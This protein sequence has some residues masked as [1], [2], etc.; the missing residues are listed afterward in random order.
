MVHTRMVRHFRQ[1]LLWPLQLMPLAA[2]RSAGPHW[3]L[4]EQGEGKTIW[5]RVEDKFALDIADPS[6]FQE[7]HYKEFI[8]F[9]PHVQRFIYGE[10]RSSHRI[11]ADPPGESALKLFRRDDIATLRLTLHEGDEPIVLSVKYVDLCFFEDT[12]VVILRVEI[13]A[14]N[15]PYLVARD[16]LYRLGRSYPTEWDESGQGVHNTYRTEWL[17]ADGSVLATSDSSNRDKFL[18]FTRKHRTSGLSSHWDYLLRPLALDSS[19]ENGAIRY[20]QIEYHRMPV[21]GLLAMDS[22]RSLNREDWIRLGLIATRHPDEALPEYD[23][24]VSGFKV[25]YCYDRY[26]TDTDAGPNTR[27]LCSGRGLLIVGDASSEYFL[28]N[29]RGMLSQFRHQYS[30]MFLIAHFHR[31]SLLLFSDHLVDAIHDLNIREANSVER[32]RRRIHHSLASF[33]RFTHRY[34]FYEL[35]ERP[36]VQSLYRMCTKHLDNEAMFAEIKEELRDMSQY[37]DSDSQRRQSATVMRLTVVTTFSLIG[38]VATGF[39]GMNIIAEAD[40]PMLTRWAYFFATV[41]GATLLTLLMVFK[42]EPL[43]KTMDVLANEK[44]SWGTK[45]AALCGISPGKTKT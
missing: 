34:W 23:L 21:M 4:L 26:W 42:S 10:Y 31:A 5:R 27:F 44:V 32:F 35:S 33:L 37:L 9:L 20:R 1:I 3:K 11:A 29:N 25:R 43:S 6:V 7:R 24:E 2:G 22:P 8:T 18:S 17:A 39:M 38:T 14:D 40:A 15:L 19:D 13:F 41:T 12:D 28:D 36:H 45:L 30:M 16:L